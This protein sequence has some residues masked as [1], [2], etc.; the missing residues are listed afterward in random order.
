MVERFNQTLR[1]MLRKSSK[2]WNHQWDQA[3][4]YVFGEYRRA[5]HSMTGF[6]PANLLYGRQMRG[7]L[8]TLK[9][10]WAI[11]HTPTPDLSTRKQSEVTVTSRADGEERRLHAI[12]HKNTKERKFGVGDLVVLRTP[13][14]GHKLWNEWEG[15]YHITKVISD[16]TYE[17]AMLD[18]PRRKVR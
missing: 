3:L 9:A 4:P 11:N 16:T 1:T 18:R 12:L 15:P 13:P 8:Q 7:L 2:L 10:A 17:L 6:T 14:I 5:P